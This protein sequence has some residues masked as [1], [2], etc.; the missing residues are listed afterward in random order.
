MRIGLVTPWDVEDPRSWS[1]VVR[2]MVHHLRK[3][4]DVDVVPCGQEKPAPVDRLAAGLMGRA[5]GMPYLTGHAVAT[6]RRHGRAL[7]RRLAYT[8]HDVVL[9]IAA[10]A[11]LAYT[12]T[13]QPLVQVTD[14]T[15][16]AIT[17]YYPLF[18]GLPAAVRYQGEIIERRSAKRTRAWVVA[19]HWVAS[20]LVDDYGVEVQRIHVAPFGPALEDIPQRS[21]F[22]GTVRALLVTSNWERK[23]GPMALEAMARAR[24]AGTEVRLTVVGDHPALPDHVTGLGRVSPARMAELY[25]RHDVLLE[26]AAAN[27]G[28]VTLTDAAHAGLPAIATR[29]GGVPDIV[30]DGVSGWLVPPGP[31]GVLEAAHLLSRLAQPETLPALACGARQHAHRVLNWQRWTEQVLTACAQAMR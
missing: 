3:E 18:T 2:P 19:S 8:D 4:A 16:G 10:S 20:S 26:L 9:G 29:T 23:G 15:F 1:G 31:Q 5:A 25:A 12:R 14:A 28:G 6:A 21:E 30:R 17:D 13:D 22:A 7:T 11:P 27:A 24:A